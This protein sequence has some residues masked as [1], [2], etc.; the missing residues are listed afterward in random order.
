MV[1]SILPTY[2]FDSA[3]SIGRRSRSKDRCEHQC[4]AQT[5]TALQGGRP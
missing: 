1:R 2:G 5:L 3:I 4:V